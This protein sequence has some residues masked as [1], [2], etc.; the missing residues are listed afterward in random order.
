MKGRESIQTDSY[1]LVC[2]AV[3]GELLINTTEKRS[4]FIVIMCSYHVL[5]NDIP[6]C[7]FSFVFIS[8][9]Y[10]IRAF[11]INVVYLISL[12]LCGQAVHKALS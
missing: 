10:D 6:S 8:V 7:S 11:V 9:L 2:R 1:F 5:N 3:G 4:E 12:S